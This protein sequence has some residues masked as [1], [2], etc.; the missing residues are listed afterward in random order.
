MAFDLTHDLDP[1][2]TRN[3][4]L[5]LDLTRNLDRACDLD[6]DLVLARDRARDI[7]RALAALPVDASGADLTE[8]QVSDR[9]LGAG[10]LDGVVWDEATR[11]PPSLREFVADRSE[12]I[13]AGVCRVRGGTERDPR[14]VPRR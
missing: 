13:A 11:W 12:E 2:L 3:L 9:A 5:A 7:A 4:D 1:A 6:L 14:A 10:V 8:V